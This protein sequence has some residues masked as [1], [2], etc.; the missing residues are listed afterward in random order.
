MDDPQYHKLIDALNEASAA[1]QSIIERFM[2]M[3]H[4]IDPLDPIHKE[5]DEADTAVEDAR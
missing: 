5:W 3:R 4:P 2:V 1:R